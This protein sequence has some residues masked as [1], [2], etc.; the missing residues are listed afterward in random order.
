MAILGLVYGYLMF[1]SVKA[2]DEHLTKRG[3]AGQHEFD[4]F[5]SARLTTDIID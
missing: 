4:V 3:S 5:F 2:A 1:G